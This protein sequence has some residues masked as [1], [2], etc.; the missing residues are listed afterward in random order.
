MVAQVLLSWRFPTCHGPAGCDAPLALASLSPRLCTQAGTHRAAT[1]GTVDPVSSLLG[2]PSVDPPRVTSEQVHGLRADFL[3]GGYTVEELEE[4]LGPRAGPAGS[5]SRSRVSSRPA[6]ESRRR[7]PTSS[8]GRCGMCRWQVASAGV[9]RGPRPAPVL[10]RGRGDFDEETLAGLAGGRGGVATAGE[11]ED[12]SVHQGAV[13][14]AR[15]LGRPLRMAQDGSV[16]VA[17]PST[18][19]AR[20]W[21]AGE[22]DPGRRRGVCRGGQGAG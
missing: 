6:S 17:S 8:V 2:T 1:V 11:G 21:L 20:Q 16:Q 5:T 18:G 19:L 22:P 4:L 9:R 14:V 7:W 15:P 13:T 12:L 3:D 10:H